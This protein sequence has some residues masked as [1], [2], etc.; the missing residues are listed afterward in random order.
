MQLDLETIFCSSYNLN[1]KK[2]KP[3]FIWAMKFLILNFRKNKFH[4]V[5]NL[6]LSLLNTLDVSINLHFVILLIGRLISSICDT[7]Y[8]FCINVSSNFSFISVSV[9]PNW[10]CCTILFL[11]SLSLV[12]NKETCMI[13]IAS[14][15]LFISQ[16]MQLVYN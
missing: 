2:S 7:I 9:K 5:M 4:L 6:I 1:F 15:F 8:A 11:G 16:K 12:R 10:L 3:I 13:C 14:V